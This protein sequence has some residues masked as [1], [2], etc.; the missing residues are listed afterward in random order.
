MA[1]QEENKQN[2]LLYE[3]I[4]EC[5]MRDSVVE[6]VKKLPESPLLVHLYSDSNTTKTRTEKAEEHNWVLVKQKWMILLQIEKTVE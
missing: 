1:K 6:I 3:K 4:D 2:E 5:R